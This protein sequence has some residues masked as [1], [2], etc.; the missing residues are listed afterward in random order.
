MKKITTTIILIVSILSLASCA[1]MT[2]PVGTSGVTSGLGGSSGSSS[3][4]AGSGSGTGSTGSDNSGA[5]TDII[6]EEVWDDYFENRWGV[7]STWDNVYSSKWF[8]NS[9]MKFDLYSYENFAAAIEELKH[10]K[11]KIVASGTTWQSSSVSIYRMDTRVSSSWTLLYQ[12]GW[13]DRTYSIEVDFSEFANKT[14][15]STDDK[16]RELAAFLANIS[17]ETGY[18]DEIGLFYREEIAYEGSSDLVY[19]DDASWF[20]HVLPAA[21]QSYHGR[22]PIQLSWNYNYGYASYA[23]YGEK[24]TLINNPDKVMTDGKVAF[25]TAIWFW[26]FPQDPKPSCHEVMY[27]SYQAESWQR[28]QWGF[29]HTAIIINGYYEDYGRMATRRSTFYTKFL[30]KL[31]TTIGSGE[32][33]NTSGMAQY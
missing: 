12:Y 21:G 22:G 15:A 25:M 14:G 5:I 32:T 33:I 6:S 7:G 31:G 23:I 9:S 20:S 30:G 26:M 28:T 24:D 2:R 4:S 1:D 17:H 13:V 27:S 19:R 18:S 3:G 11:L 16:N 8:Y 29:G 10:I